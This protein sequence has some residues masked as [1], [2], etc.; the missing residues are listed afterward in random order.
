LVARPQTFRRHF[1]SKGT[2]E[3]PSNQHP[4]NILGDVALDG[5]PGSW[6]SKDERFLRCVP[7]LPSLRRSE[8]CKFDQKAVLGRLDNLVRGPCNFC[9]NPYVDMLPISHLRPVDLIIGIMLRLCLVKSNRT[10][11]S[12]S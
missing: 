7:V 4:V 11:D 1:S 9:R 6:T 5:D 3:Y 10:L 8:D 12:Y 2:L